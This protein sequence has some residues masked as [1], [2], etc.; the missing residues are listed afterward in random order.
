MYPQN[1]DANHKSVN[2]EEKS[3]MELTYV[4]A[5]GDVPE[6][7]SGGFLS[8]HTLLQGQRRG[9]RDQV[10][11]LNRRAEAATSCLPRF[12]RNY[13]SNRPWWWL[14]GHSLS[15]NLD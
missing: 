15:A 12:I 6:Q 13:I 5:A 2:Y 14:S 9:L 10:Q 3:F 8:H 4:L 11:R 1:V 7:V